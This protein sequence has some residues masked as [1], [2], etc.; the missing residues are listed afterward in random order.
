VWLPDGSGLIA[1]A[2]DKADQ[3]WEIPYPSGHPRQITNFTTRYN[4]ASLTA[5]GHALVAVEETNLSGIWIGPAAEPDRVRRVTSPGARTVGF[6]GLTWMPDGRVIYWSND[7]DQSDFMLMGADGSNAQRLPLDGLK[8]FPNVCPDGHTLLFHAPDPTTARDTVMRADLD[9]G[10][11]QAI[12]GTNAWGFIHCTSDGKWA[13]YSSDE[14]KKLHKIPLEGGTPIALTDRACIP[15]ALSPDGR[16]IAC[17][18]LPEQG[19]PKLAILPFAGGPP[20]KVL[21]LP[22]TV[23]CLRQLSQSNEGFLTPFAWTP[24]GRAVAFVDNRDGVGNLWAQPI[25]GGAPVKLTHFTA[26]HIWYFAFS[27]D[28]RQI[29]I[30]RGTSTTDAV[31]ITNFR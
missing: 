19:A 12:K 24:D 7:R 10:Q 2:Y 8:W 14:E 3:L 28:G 20:V 9:G 22:P 18:Y 25:A 29:A 23:V 13:V 30:A 27:R 16:L 6:A 11:P 4:Q 31:L 26:E 5:D 21:D 15:S 17:H 1:P